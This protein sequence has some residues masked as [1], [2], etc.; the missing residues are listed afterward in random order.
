MRY[1][2]VN[3]TCVFSL[4]FPPGSASAED[5]RAI[6]ERAIQAHGGAA[7]LERTKK[8]HLQGN[9]EVY[10]ENAIAKYE[11][12]EWFDLPRRYKLTSDRINSDTPV[13]RESGVDGEEGWKREGKG[14]VREFTLHEPEPLF[15]HWHAILAQLLLLR[16]KNVQLTSLPE[17]TR[18]KRVFTGIHATSLNDSRDFFF[19]KT[20]GLVERTRLTMRDPRGGKDATAETVYDDYRDIHGILYPM[21]FKVYTGKANSSTITLSS[22]EFLDKIGDSVFL[23]SQIPTAEGPVET[24]AAQKT[25]SQPS[26]ENGEKPL[27]SRDRVLIVATVAAGVVVGAVWFIVRASKRGKREMPPS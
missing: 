4:L 22:I 2:V 11:I 15:Q 10:Q 16:E 1:Y 26:H 18:D 13:H 5:T 21:R 24:S 27:A 7:R 20:T 9:T 23:K 8:G 6:V 12:E 19:D 17:E 14:P 3:S 25:T